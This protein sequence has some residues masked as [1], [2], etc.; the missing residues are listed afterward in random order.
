[1]DHEADRAQQRGKHS[2]G[3][4][5]PG[6]KRGDERQ[7]AVEEEIDAGLVDFFEHF[8]RGEA[9][10]DARPL[11]DHAAEGEDDQKRGQREILILRGDLGEL[12][13]NND[14]RDDD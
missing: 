13:E 4:L 12:R 5:Q 9:G 3:R 14:Q 2:G 1:M 11:E 6:K 8:W 10:S 7:Q